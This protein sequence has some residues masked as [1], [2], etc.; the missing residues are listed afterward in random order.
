MLNKEL[1]V[2]IDVLHR[3]GKGIRTIACCASRPRPLAYWV[4]VLHL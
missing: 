1:Q 2:E 4:F 3:Q